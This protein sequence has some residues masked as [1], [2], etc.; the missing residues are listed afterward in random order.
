M[1]PSD[2]YQAAQAQTEK[3]GEVLYQW[4]ES[5]RTSLTQDTKLDATAR[6]RLG[7]LILNACRY[8]AEREDAAKKTARE[9]ELK[10]ER[11]ARDRR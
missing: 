6:A 1:T 5:A 2:A 10:A 9:A 4:V 7:E 8:L 3:A 11:Q